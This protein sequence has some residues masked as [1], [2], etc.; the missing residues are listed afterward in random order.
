[1]RA[2]EAIHSGNLGTI[3]DPFRLNGGVYVL[4]ASAT[5][6][7]GSVGLQMLLGDGVTYVAALTALTAAGISPPA[8]LP[9]GT[10]RFVIVTATAVVADVTRVPFD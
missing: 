6:G 10:Y 9:P 4:G 5:F 8:Y 7:G 3:T 2:Q 1:M